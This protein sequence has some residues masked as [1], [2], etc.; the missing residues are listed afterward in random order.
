MWREEEEEALELPSLRYI[1][2]SKQCGVTWSITRVFSLFDDCV[3]SVTDMLVIREVLLHTFS[4]TCTIR[5]CANIRPTFK[6]SSCICNQTF[7]NWSFGERCCSVTRN[8]KDR[9][10]AHVFSMARVCL[11]EWQHCIPRCFLQPQRECETTSVA[12]VRLWS[13]I[14]MY[15]SVI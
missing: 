5:V 9:S 14:M 3:T 4:L 2:W 1:P 6:K 13:L 15:T 10:L 8:A 11:E 7:W 12:V